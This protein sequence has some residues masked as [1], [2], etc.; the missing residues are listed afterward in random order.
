MKNEMLGKFL[1][2]QGVTSKLVSLDPDIQIYAKIDKMMV[3][4]L[5]SAMAM[6]SPIL[7]SSLVRGAARRRAR[8]PTPW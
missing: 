6:K 7:I 2:L 8:S 4:E 3:G 5:L 1:D